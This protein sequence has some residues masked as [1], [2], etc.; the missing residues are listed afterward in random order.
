[1]FLLPGTS[2]YVALTFT[3]LCSSEL[4]SAPVSMWDPLALRVGAACGKN[5]GGTGQTLS[6]RSEAPG[7]LVGSGQLAPPRPLTEGMCPLPVHM[8][9][10][11]P[12][13]DVM[14]GW[15][16]QEVTVLRGHEGGSHECPVGQGLLPH[17]L[18]CEDTVRGR[19]SATWKRPLTDID[20]AGTL[21]LPCNLHAVRN[22]FLLFTS[23]PVRS[24]WSCGALVEPRP[25]PPAVL[26]L[27]LWTGPYLVQDADHYRKRA[28]GQ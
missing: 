3:G 9:K 13:C 27:L 7:L 23:Q 2:W 15:G 20:R 26:P 6:R 25:P 22:K 17:P 16:L 28:W 4:P 10:P 14:K 21:I 24:P 18:P 8:L 5:V 19:Q 12:W 11:H 1:M